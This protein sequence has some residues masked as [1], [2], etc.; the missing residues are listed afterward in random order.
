V[1]IAAAL[2]IG[3]CGGH[4]GHAAK[5]APTAFPPTLQ[6]ADC[7]QWNEMRPASRNQLVEQ[8]RLFFGARVNGRYG[9]GQTLSRDQALRVLTNGCRPAYADAV[10]L[11]KLY[12]R[13]AAF[14]P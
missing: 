6:T 11:Y 8:M 7:G 12:G 14:T 9:R 10:K 2:A 4:Q 1:T 3:G 5:P 13:A